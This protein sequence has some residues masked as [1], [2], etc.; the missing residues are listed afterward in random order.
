MSLIPDGIY[1]RKDLDRLLWPVAWNGSTPAETREE[2]K[3]MV[4]EIV[5]KARQALDLDAGCV[6]VE[7]RNDKCVATLAEGV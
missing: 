6:S 1:T 2:R 5:F 3:R 4:R 7:I